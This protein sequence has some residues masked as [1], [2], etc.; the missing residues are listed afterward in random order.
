MTYTLTDNEYNALQD[1]TS[2]NGMD[3]WFCLKQDKHGKDYIYDLEA[4]KRI[5][6]TSALSYIYEG[7]LQEDFDELDEKEQNALEGLF[8]RYL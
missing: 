3:C 4:G 6:I 2:I 8:K 7:L 5:S 1:I